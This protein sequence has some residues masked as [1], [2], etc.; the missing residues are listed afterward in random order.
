MKSFVNVVQSVKTAFLDVGAKHNATPNSV[1][2]TWL[3]ESVTLTSVSRV[4]LLTI[5][6]VKMYPVRTVAFSGALK[7]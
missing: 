4:E 2:A 5:G 1:H 7:R 6:T 3:S